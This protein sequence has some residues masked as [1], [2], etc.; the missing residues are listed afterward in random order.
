MCFFWSKGIVFFR[1]GSQFFEGM[2]FFSNKFCFFFSGRRIFFYCF[3]SKSFFYKF[4]L[5]MNGFLLK[6]FSFFFEV[7]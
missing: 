4:F 5:K 1:I 2:F 3:S 7:S 6:V